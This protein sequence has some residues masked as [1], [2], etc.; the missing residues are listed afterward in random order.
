[1]SFVERVTANLK[2]VQFFSVGG[3]DG[4]ES[5]PNGSESEGSFSG[6]RCFSCGSGLAGDRH[7]AHGFIA[8]TEEEARKPECLM[9]HFEVCTDC[10]MFH[11]NGDLPDEHGSPPRR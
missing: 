9:E 8:A 2:G 4:C 7:P 10:V 11:A 1:M 5:C 3:C 6:R